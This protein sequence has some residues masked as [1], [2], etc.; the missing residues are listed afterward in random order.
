MAFQRLTYC[1]WSQNAGA[2]DVPSRA[3]EGSKVWNAF[4]LGT[5]GSSAE[6]WRRKRTLRTR[7]HLSVVPFNRIKW[8][9]LTLWISISVS[10]MDAFERDSVDGF[11]VID[12]TQWID[13]PHHFESAQ[14][15]PEVDCSTSKSMDAHYRFNFRHRM[16][17]VDWSIWQLSI[18]RDILLENN[19]L[20]CIISINGN[21][22]FN[23]VTYNTTNIQYF[24]KGIAVTEG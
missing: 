11:R 5:N 17:M 4:T 22:I 12:I 19:A 14:S 1:Q 8:W 15:W 9:P 10:L 18:G 3:T 20:C 6:T 7:S 21:N 24:R 13:D 16:F 23:S 2:S